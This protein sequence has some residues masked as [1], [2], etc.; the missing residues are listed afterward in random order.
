GGDVAQLMRDIGARARAAARTLALTEPAKK[1]AALRAAAAAVREDSKKILQANTED[2]N[3]ARRDNATPAF[4]DRLMLDEKRVAAMA[5]GT[6]TLASVT[7]PVGG[8]IASGQRPNGLQIGRVRPPLGV[9]AVVYES[10]PN[11]TA[12][13]G[14]LAIKAGNAVILRGGSESFRSARAIH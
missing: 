10:R 1:A 8:E 3:E 7:D 13:A 12:D 9:V 2:L 14:A 6:E 11:V 5:E 4:L